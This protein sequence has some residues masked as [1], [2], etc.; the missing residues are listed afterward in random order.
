MLDR[1][2]RPPEF[3]KTEIDK[4]CAIRD[5]EA[6]KAYWI[7]QGYFGIHT[8]IVYTPACSKHVPAWGVRSNIGPNGFPPR[9]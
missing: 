1:L 8:E 6:I 5:A 3:Y 9:Q 7:D 2:L 4:A